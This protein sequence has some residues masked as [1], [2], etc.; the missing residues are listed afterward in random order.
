[1]IPLFRL[2]TF[3]DSFVIL[4]ETFNV[5]RSFYEP[6]SPAGKGAKWEWEGDGQPGA[7]EWHT[8]DMEVQ[9]LIESAWASGQ[10][11]IDISKTPLGFPYII[12]FLNLTQVRANTGYVRNVHRIP[13]AP[14]PL[15]KLSPEEM[16]NLAGKPI[17]SLLFSFL[18]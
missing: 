18:T 10:Q 14:Y 3:I 4:D 17:F 6:S 13:Q 16:S 11:R 15:I 5:R 2:I 7:R 8:Y 9:C 1:M 12:N